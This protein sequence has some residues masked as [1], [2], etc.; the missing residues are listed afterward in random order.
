ME[1]SKRDWTGVPQEMQMMIYRKLVGSQ[2]NEDAQRHGQ[3]DRENADSGGDSDTGSG[4][5][6][7]L[8]PPGLIASLWPTKE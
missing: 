8:F 2:E 1:Y 3:V 5:G 6:N 7:R 4:D